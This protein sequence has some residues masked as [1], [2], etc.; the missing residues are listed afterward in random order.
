MWCNHKESG[1]HC[2]RHK[3]CGFNIWVGKT[4]RVGNDNPLQ[5]SCLKNSMDRRA[6]QTIVHRV[7][8]RDQFCFSGKIEKHLSLGPNPTI[9]ENVKSF[10][11]SVTGSMIEKKIDFPFLPTSYPF[12]VKSKEVKWSEVAQ[13]CLTLGDPTDC[14]PPG[15]HPWNFLGKSTGV[16]CHFL[17]LG[18]SQP[19]DQTQVSGIAGRHFILW[20][21]SVEGRPD[22]KCVVLEMR[23]YEKMFFWTERFYESHLHVLWNLVWNKR[24]KYLNIVP[25]N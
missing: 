9:L 22:S 1:C 18:S 25:S 5:Y 7:V 13:L 8:Y 15:L 14:S 11:L 4:H 10:W 21:T 6:W 23:Q 17:L 20:A 2:R 24:W 19:R 16:G 12:G 3:R